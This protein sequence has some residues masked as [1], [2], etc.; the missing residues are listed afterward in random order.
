MVSGVEGEQSMIPVMQRINLQELS[1]RK[2]VCKCK[3]ACDYGVSMT[4]Y[5]DG[6][7]MCW[8]DSRKSLY[9]LINLL[10]TGEDAVPGKYTNWTRTDEEFIISLVEKKG[11]FRG[12]NRVIAESLGKTYQQAKSKTRNMKKQGK[13]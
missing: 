12:I 5:N 1:D 9:N 6:F 7:I 13:I 2:K 10:E 11:M 3:T 8:N 4:T